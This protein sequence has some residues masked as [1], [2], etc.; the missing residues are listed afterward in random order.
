MLSSEDELGCRR[1]T[2]KE[3]FTGLLRRALT[4]TPTREVERID[5]FTVASELDGD[6]LVKTAGLRT[7]REVLVPKDSGTRVWQPQLLRAC[8]ISLIVGGF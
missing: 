4:M 6:C 1:D 3:P 8:G 5:D 2:V 7:I